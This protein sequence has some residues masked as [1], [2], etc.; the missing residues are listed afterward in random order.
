MSELA[1][2]LIRENIEAHKRG[3]DATTL[4]LGN[5]GM[6]EVPKEMG[7]C[8]WVETLLLSS[9]W[10]EY[11]P[12]KKKGEWKNTQN[13]G[14]PNQ[15]TFLPPTLPLLTLLK[16]IG[17][18]DTQV[19]DLSPLANLTNLNTLFCDSTQV[20]DLSPLANLTNLNSLSCDSTQVS[21]L[22]PL[23][24]LTN[25]NTLYCYSTQVSDLSPIL[26][27]IKKGRQVKWEESSGNI[28]VKGCPLVN[29]PVEIVKQGNEAILRY[30]E[31][32]E[33]QQGTAKLFEAKIIIVGEGE[34]GKTTLFEKLKD[35]NHDPI[36]NPS[37]ETHGIN[38]YE[39]LPMH[40]PSLGARHVAANLWDFGG[41]E[42]QYMT[43]QFFLTPRALY[44]LL[45][46]ARS[47]SPNLAYWFKII[48]LLGKESEDSSEKVPL[49]LVFNKRPDST[50]K[51]P[52][53]QDVLK[54]YDNHLDPHY[55]EADLA[56]NKGHFH[57]VR[58]RLE[59]MAAALPIIQSEVPKQWKPIR[60]ALREEAEKIPYITAERLAEICEPFGVTDWKD[61]FQLTGYLH[62][63]GSLLHFQ[64]DKELMA[65]IILSPKW[66][67]DGVYTFLK[68]ERLAKQ[69]GRFSGEWFL[70]L[71]CEKGYTR[72]GGQKILQMMTKDNFDICYE[73]SKGHY[74]AAQLL[75]DNAPEHT[76]H[77]NDCLQ[78]RYQYPIMPK[79]L[80]S[81]LIVRLSEYLE[82]GPQ[83][84]EQIVWKKGAVLRIP[85]NGQD[86]RVRI[87][88]DDAESPS[89]LRQ[90][91]VEVLGE[92]AFRK[93]GLQRVRQEVNELHRLWFRSIH[94]DEM[95]PCCCER[96]CQKAEKPYLHKLEKLLNL[97][98]NRRKLTAECGESGDDIRIDLMLEGVYEKAEI[99]KFEQETE[100][101]QERRGGDTYHVYGGQFN[102]IERIEQMEIHQQF[103]VSKEDFE[104]LQE[105]VL[106]LSEANREELKNL[107]AELPAP[108]NEAE[109]KSIGD[110]IVKGMN[111]LAIPILH[112]VTGSAYYDM[113]KMFLGVA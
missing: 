27:L 72:P 38:I 2:R 81:R 36:K 52:Q 13:E 94:A 6:T 65:T 46:N 23:A 25:L 17:F 112:E 16:K 66:A 90:I 34:T 18:N 12:E 39:G 98:L 85:H 29:P 54:Y 84:G 51:T 20:S 109:K 55:I 11:D 93:Y 56:V 26:P 107:I 1:L 28:R 64:E 24:N 21:D 58:S 8:V 40:H 106:A 9:G 35:E 22:S 87:M 53:W 68:D 71:L 37:G 108:K 82:T 96:H 10:W 59:E 47:E 15:L 3:E 67:V 50:G 63:L 70:D 103:G 7:E 44:V 111:D 30:F 77:K 104:K 89:G 79:G 19:S 69:N 45:M 102:K 14:E 33:A 91:I 74:V 83:S 101:G 76:F 110:K 43:H 60:D 80:M 41:Q 57:I 97:K 99:K 4:D 61:Q 95:V 105:S 32:I 78:F 42:L 113:L 75:P 86:C 62:R 49:L 100:K 73:A 48:S 88:E 5:C 31:Q 92:H